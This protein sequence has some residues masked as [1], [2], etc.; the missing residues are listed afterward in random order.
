MLRFAIFAIAAL[1]SS[2]SQKGKRM[3]QPPRMPDVAAQR[4]AMKKLEFLV[5]NWS[6]EAR[7]FRAGQ[8][9]ELAQSEHAEFKIDGLILEIEGAGRSKADGKALLQ[10]LG[11]VSY[12]VER[13][14]YRFRAFNDGR[15]LESD[16]KLG[17]DGSSMSW[18]FTVGEFRTSSVLRITPEGHWTEH[19]EITIGTQPARKL[20]DVDV[21][22]V[23]KQK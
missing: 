21:A 5:G 16:V 13:Q 14:T 4:A 23:E 2:A 17:D 22:R 3:P 11:I 20:M 12:D 1:L 10:A 15:W 7:M 19:H 18:G 6:G 8:T 9:I